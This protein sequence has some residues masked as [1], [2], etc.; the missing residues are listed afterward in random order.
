VLAGR[1]R[2]RV[3]VRQLLDQARGSRGSALVLHG[4]PGVGKST[5]LDCVAADAGDFTV[6][7]TSGIESE[8]PLAFAALQRLLRPVL[9]LTDRLPDP[10]ARALRRAFGQQDGEVDRFLVFLATLSL[11]AEAAEESPVLALVDDAHWLDD[12][13]AAAL[14]FV[15][16]RLHAERVALL[17][18][19]RDGDVRR[20]DADDLPHVLLAELGSADAGALLATTT[21]VAVP[22]AVL[23]RLVHG[24]GGNPLALVELA[25]ALTT[26][27]L[28]GRTALPLDLPLTAGV[29]RVFL[30]RV[31]RL[32]SGA[33]TFL[34][35]AAAD[36]SG[37]A[38]SVRRAAL[39]L[40]VSNEAI[41]AAE[42]SGLIN[43][44]DGTVTLRHPLVRS[45]VYGAATGSQRRAA[46]RALA[47]ALVGSGDV[48]R[49]AWHRAA[50]AEDPDEAVVA[51]LDGVA[52]RASQRGGL[53]AACAAWERAAEL[54]LA[55][56]PRAAR[57]LSA[58]DAAWA[59]AQPGRA[60]ALAEA[61]RAATDD[62]LVRADVDRLRARI[63]WNIG[64]G[65]VGHR[66]L[67]QA[68]R[69]VAG[70]DPS[71]ARVMA[72]MAAAAATF[73]VDSGI[74]VD[75]ADFV[76][77]LDSIP[78]GPERSS[79]LLLSGFAHIA[80]GDLRAATG[81]FRSAFAHDPVGGDSDLVQNLGLAA[82][83]IGDDNTA[84]DRYGR[85]VARAREA[86]A[87]VMILYGLARR[88][89]AE[90]STGDWRTAAAGSAEAW[91][92][93]RGTG[94]DPLGSLP[95]AW[96]TL[97]A[98][99]RGDPDAFT[100]NLAEFENPTRARDTGLTSIVSH[101]VML[102][103][104]GVD[105]ADP[106]AALHHL[107]QITHPMVRNMS[108]MDRITAATRSGREQHAVDWA[109][110]LATIAEQT[111]AA[112]ATAAAA[113]THALLADGTQAQ[114]LF[115]RALQA[116]ARSPRRP[117]RART[118][119]AFGEYL[120]RSRRR[121]DARE[122]LRSALETFEDLQATRWAAR[123]RQEL[124]A[125]GETARKRDSSNT[126]DLTAQ[127]LHVATLIRHGLNNR[128][129][130]AQL[131]VS[132]RTVDF[133]LR[134]VFTKLGISSRAELAALDLG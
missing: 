121:I 78:Q 68:A 59:S 63:E 123:A 56:R 30:E 12:A 70:T 2:E 92:L 62:V 67:L 14:L 107:E 94:Q 102:W 114:T 26:D 34:L 65:P 53:E 126:T 69:D 20:F 104:K 74:D 31:R 17:C 83:Y 81:E 71:R 76:G 51:D 46:H 55:T 75:P 103:A 16:R 19:A 64:S 15:A 85:F 35:I 49:R 96:L 22:P 23:D 29:E 88:A 124:R 9:R 60:R 5:L 42:D 36:D 130:A 52:Q 91:D 99:L 38:V 32:P 127:E 109:G 33:R 24:T 1:D 48:D 108:A 115:E 41:I 132:P 57:L 112:W 79:G 93:A 82:L 86:G 77:D 111:G 3:A 131:F 47:E 43:V 128:D 18:A 89:A 25:G 28:S 61:A 110:E 120:R 134:N 118:Q 58:A 125:S 80:R 105:A 10:Q 113:H 84:L 129:A 101:D 45:A 8:S 44:H 11:L 66:I 97:L 106:Q 73:G 87:P 50:A 27:Q 40:G 6:L 7:R 90:I 54:T 13:S 100:R 37:R 4:L 98:A 116:H 39:A 133:H 95:L 117:D 119:L 21:G 72:R 122:H